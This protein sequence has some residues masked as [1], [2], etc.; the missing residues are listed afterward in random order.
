MNAKFVEGGNKSSHCNV[1]VLLWCG[2][3]SLQRAGLSQLL[4]LDVEG[5]G[6][7]PV[8]GGLRLAQLEPE[9]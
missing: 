5:D 7:D 2:V 4:L 6:D 8:A 1:V 9:P 3:L